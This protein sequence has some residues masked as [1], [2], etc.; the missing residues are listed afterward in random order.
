VDLDGDNHLDIISGSWPGE[1][2]FFKRNADGSFAA[3]VKLKDKDGKTINIGGGVRRS[4]E[5]MVLIAGDAT[6]EKN[7]D[8]DTVVIYEGERIPVP[9]GESVG[10]TG[11]ASAVHAAD[12]NGDGTLDLLVGDI[13]GNVYLIVNEGTKAKPVFAKEQQLN[14][15]GKPLRVNGDA[16]PFVCDW[17][18]DGAIDL[19]VG[20]GEGAVWFFR[21]EGTSKIPELAARVQL[22]PPANVRF[23]A[24][25]AKEPRRGVRAKVCAIDWTGAGRLDLLV[26]DFATQKPDRPEPTPEQKAN[27]EKAQEELQSVQRRYSALIQQLRGRQA[28]KDKQ[29]RK[30]IEEELREA[31]ETM[32]SLYKRVPRDYENHGWVWLFKRKPIEIEAASK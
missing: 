25:A 12:F 32:Q 28:V 29:E 10:I 22:V 21:N 18:A 27:Q 14:A 30:K 17:D 20:D 2:F 5:N 11:T 24:D 7:D 9:E 3:P 6:Y 4:S 26:G 15:G 1:L 19:L 13:G 8:G 23:G 16:G 31:S